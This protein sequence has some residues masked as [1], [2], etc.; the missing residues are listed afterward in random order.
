MIIIS[1]YSRVMR[2][3]KPNPKNYPSWLHVIGGLKDQRIVQV[4]IPGE[5]RMVEDFRSGLSLVDLRTLLAEC[6]TWISVDNFFPHLAHH[7]AKPGVVLWGQS[8]PL[9]FG[10]PENRNLLKDR[11][12]LRA[13]Q[14]DIWEAVEYNPLV[15]VEPQVVIQAVREVLD[16]G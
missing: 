1:P 8:D 7:A 6:E 15:F 14:F 16:G 13:N 9:V 11:S 2:N 3:G 5:A 12:H 4:G 10:Y